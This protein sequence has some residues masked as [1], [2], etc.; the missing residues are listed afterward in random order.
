MKTLNRL[1]PGLLVPFIFAFALGSVL[2][3]PKALAYSH[4]PTSHYTSN[5]LR[6]WIP[7]QNADIVV[8][9]LPIL[10]F[11]GSLL[12]ASPTTDMM[13]ELRVH[14]SSPLKEAYWGA[15]LSRFD[16]PDFFL[17]L[18]RDGTLAKVDNLAFQKYTPKA[19]SASSAASVGGPY[20]DTRINFSGDAARMVK[21]FVQ[22]STD[23]VVT[24]KTDSNDTVCTFRQ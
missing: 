7:D 9:S 6:A 2:S 18:N 4:G 21:D 11:N 1:N 8:L 16:S 23:S 12:G 14:A 3:P 24:C 10:S 19:I 17:P 5:H 15:I 13:N 22:A 20:T